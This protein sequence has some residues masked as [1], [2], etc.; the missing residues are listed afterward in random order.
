MNEDFVGDVAADVCVPAE[1]ATFASYGV[2]EILACVDFV[3]VGAAGLVQTLQL[4][5]HQGWG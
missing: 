3:T 2:R 1:F 4:V 5:H